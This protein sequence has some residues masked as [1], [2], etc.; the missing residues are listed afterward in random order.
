[1]K[2]LKVKMPKLPILT[3]S[4]IG[5]PGEVCAGL[6]SG[7]HSGTTSRHALRSNLFL[8][9]NERKKPVIGAGK[10]GVQYGKKSAMGT[11]AD[12]VAK[13]VRQKKK[14]ITPY[15]PTPTMHTLYGL[16]DMRKGGI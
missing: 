6:Y 4:P 16:E 1:M 12:S 14:V 5:S 15:K 3:R 13:P 10:G 7:I 8:G 2:T 11:M 9:D